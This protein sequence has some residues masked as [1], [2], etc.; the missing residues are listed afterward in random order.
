MTSVVV[1]GQMEQARQLLLLEFGG[2]KNA[3]FFSLERNQKNFSN[4][5]F[6]FIIL[7][8]YYCK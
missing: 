3:D 2:S 7:G 1:L 6:V 5:F 8:R 4:F